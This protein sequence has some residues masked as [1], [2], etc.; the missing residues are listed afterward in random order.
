MAIRKQT[1]RVGETVRLCPDL[2]WHVC[3]NPFPLE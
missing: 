2:N 1:R 3:L